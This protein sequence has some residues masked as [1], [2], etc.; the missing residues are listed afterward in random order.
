MPIS[1]AM[2]KDGLFLG[3]KRENLKLCHSNDRS[4]G[5][6]KVE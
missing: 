2:I 3:C 4:N 6:S 5:Y 1:N